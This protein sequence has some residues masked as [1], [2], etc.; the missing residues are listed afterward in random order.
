MEIY[1]SQKEREKGREEATPP[2][3]VSFVD[4]GRLREKLGRT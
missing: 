4:N 1:I 2:S 3:D